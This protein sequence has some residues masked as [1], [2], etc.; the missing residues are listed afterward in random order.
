MSTQTNVKDE[1][2]NTVN[3]TASKET[4]KNE[5]EVIKSKTVLR[6]IEIIEKITTENNNTPEKLEK[7]EKPISVIYTRFANW[8]PLS[9]RNIDR[10]IQ[11][12]ENSKNQEFAKKIV[13]KIDIKEWDN[14]STFIRNFLKS[15]DS[16]HIAEKLYDIT[17]AS[18]LENRDN[19]IKFVSSLIN[20][21]VYK[22]DPTK[23]IN[24]V[25]EKLK[26]YPY[27]VDFDFELTQD[28]EKR[29]EPYK[30][31]VY[32]KDGKK[33]FMIRWNE[34]LVTT[35]NVYTS[36]RYIKH[37]IFLWVKKEKKEWENEKVSWDI[38]AF[39]SWVIDNIWTIDN[40]NVDD[41]YIPTLDQWNLKYTLES[42]KTW[43]KKII[44]NENGKTL[45][46]WLEANY[47]K[48]EVKNLTTF[49][50]I[51]LDS[52]KINLEVHTKNWNKKIFKEID[53]YSYIEPNIIM[54]KKEWLRSYFKIEEDWD[55][56]AINFLQNINSFIYPKNIKS[57]LSNYS[58]WKPVIIEKNNWEFCLVESDRKITVLE[59]KIVEKVKNTIE[60]N[61]I[62]F[63]IWKI[64][65][66]YYEAKK[67]LYQINAPKKS[68]K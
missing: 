7:T 30:L 34:R 51:N 36:I 11:F 12:F 53:L 1:V 38:L 42:G 46:E 9:Q 61:S 47:D 56:L 66:Y 4:C 39:N 6:I 26:N 54:I 35:D 27:K 62:S 48:I 68:K 18:L 5:T 33:W 24:H 15:S 49:A 64:D 52:W 41:K 59:I 58:K 13:S 65:Y 57:I 2:I 50:S 10:L 23:F 21:I 67:E 16:L 14:N 20:W 3:D 43:F 60:Q 45:E 25:I 63:K 19:I 44:K 31:F 28:L 40:I 37:W 17:K 8:Y 55:I 29:Y 32:K 22:N